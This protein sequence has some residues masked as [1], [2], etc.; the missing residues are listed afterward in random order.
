MPSPQI[1]LDYSSA[2]LSW[3]IDPDDRDLVPGSWRVWY[4]A[5]YYASFR[6]AEIGRREGLARNSFVSKN[7]PLFSKL[8]IDMVTVSRLFEKEQLFASTGA[9]ATWEQWAM[10]SA[11][12]CKPE[13]AEWLLHEMRVI[14]EI[15]LIEKGPNTILPKEFMRPELRRHLEFL[16]GRNESVETIE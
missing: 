11:F 3:R 12:Y 2:W 5:L 6:Y 8:L 16:A 14:E 15:C 9:K 7:G 4:E 10:L 13:V 1:F